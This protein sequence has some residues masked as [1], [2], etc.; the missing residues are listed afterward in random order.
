MGGKPSKSSNPGSNDVIMILL[1]GPTGAGK[2]S[3]INKALGSETMPVNHK[4]KPHRCKVTHVDMKFPY[5]DGGQTRKI[6]FVDTP[7]LNRGDETGQSELKSKIAAWRRKNAK[8]GEIAGIL[9][10]DRITDNRATKPPL[11]QLEDFAKLYGVSF[12]KTVFLVTTHWDDLS[13]R[14][15]GERRE[16]EIRENY[17]RAPFPHPLRHYHSRE[18][19]R[20]VVRCFLQDCIGDSPYGG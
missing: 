11:K 4:L 6:I 3:F 16:E 15:V 9:Y 18:S 7:G 2:S 14:L 17:W 20:N 10:L 8:K 19:A 13:E 12:D 1:L 5:G